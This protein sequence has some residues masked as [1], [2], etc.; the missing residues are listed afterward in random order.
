MSEVE[1]VEMYKNKQVM[2]K[3]TDKAMTGRFFLFICSGK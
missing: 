1:K 3:T 2:I